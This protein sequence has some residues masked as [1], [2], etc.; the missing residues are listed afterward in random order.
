M[1]IAGPV[2]RMLLNKVK[3]QDPVAYTKALTWLEEQ[4]IA[5]D[6]GLSTQKRLT[7]PKS[8]IA[9]D[10]KTI[11]LPK[12][13]ASTVEAREAITRSNKYKIGNKPVSTKAEEII[14]VNK[15][16]SSSDRNI[17][18]DDLKDKDPKAYKEVI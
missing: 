4:G 17:V 10:G 15:D 8:K 11:Q 12:D 13:T 18:L 9:G 2:K 7:A 1:K 6:I 3:K 5:R 16:L 14:D